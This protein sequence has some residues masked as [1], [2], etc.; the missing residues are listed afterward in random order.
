MN[1][2]DS[3]DKVLLQKALQRQ[4]ET[5]SIL[6]FLSDYFREKYNLSPGDQV[7]PNGEIANTQPSMFGNLENLNEATESSNG[8]LSGAVGSSQ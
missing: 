5:N 4:A 6:A 3:S 1:E 2:I 8:T 7:M